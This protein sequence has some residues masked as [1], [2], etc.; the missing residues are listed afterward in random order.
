MKK[1][2]PSAYFDIAKGSALEN[3]NKEGKW[4]ADK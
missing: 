4:E 2:F 1:R 3:R